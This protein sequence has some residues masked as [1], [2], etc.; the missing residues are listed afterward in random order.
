[1]KVTPVTLAGYGVRIEPLAEAHLAGLARAAA[2]DGIWDYMSMDLREPGA[3]ALWY[4]RAQA[5][6]AKGGECP[7]AILRAADGAPVGSTRFLNIEPAHKRLEI[8]WTWLSPPAM[9]TS[10]NTACKRLL[11]AHAFETLGAIR[12]ELRTDARNLRSRQAILRLGAQAEGILR[13]HMLIRGYVRDTAQ[14]AIADHDWPHVR[15]RLE[16][17]LGVSDK[18]P[19]R[20]GTP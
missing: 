5:G 9:R 10:I 15:A 16:R 1:M 7:F 20:G 2:F 6:V 12:V 18:K 8:G 3:V 14:F 11:L 19:D 4:Q 13:R 17:M